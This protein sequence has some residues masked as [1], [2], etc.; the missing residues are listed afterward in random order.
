MNPALRSLPPSRGGFSFFMVL[1]K[2]YTK[3][4]PIDKIKFFGSNYPSFTF[5]ENHVE[6]ILLL[7]SEIVLI[8][9][10][11]GSENIRQKLSEYFKKYYPQL[12]IYYNE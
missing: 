12:K 2:F 9:T 5:F 1:K 11:K 3:Q 8:E 7:D 10:R 4:N 6:S